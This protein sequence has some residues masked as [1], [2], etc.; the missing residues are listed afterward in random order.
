MTVEH[1]RG[2]SADRQTKGL[3][4]FIF[5]ASEMSPG[6]CGRQLLFS[7]VLEE[8]AEAVG[9]EMLMSPVCTVKCAYKTH[10]IGCFGWGRGGDLEAS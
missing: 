1:E 6:K 9:L 7:H 5:D 10:L 2:S 4:S 8:E 3:V